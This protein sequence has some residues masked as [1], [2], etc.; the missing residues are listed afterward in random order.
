M[1]E[2]RI[3]YVPPGP[4]C[5]RI[6]ARVRVSRRRFGRAPLMAVVLLVLGWGAYQFGVAEAARQRAVL[7]TLGRAYDISALEG[8]AS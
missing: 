1:K 3:V 7:V 6:V 4:S 8:D 5:A 2:Q